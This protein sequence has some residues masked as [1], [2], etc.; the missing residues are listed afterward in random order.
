MLRGEIWLGVWPADPQQTPRPLLIVSNNLRN[1]ASRLH[2]VVVLKLTSLKT[3]TGQTKPTNP[4]ED[5]VITLKKPT[6]IRCAAIY[7]VEKSYLTKKLT[8]IS[9]DELAKVEACLKIVLALG[10]N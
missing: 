6:I 1:R 7:A 5:V 9:A 3:S 4:S 8:Q 10:D 2:D